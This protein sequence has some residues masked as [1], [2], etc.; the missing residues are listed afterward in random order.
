MNFKF[1]SKVFAISLGSLPSNNM[2]FTTCAFLDKGRLLHIFSAVK[3]E[4]IFN[5]GFTKTS[6]LFCA[7][8]AFLYRSSSLIL[9]LHLI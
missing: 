1:S 5:S 7:I 2:L 3:T 6:F 9:F 4:R 8:Q